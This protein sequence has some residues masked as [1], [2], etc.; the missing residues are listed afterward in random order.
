MP[1][2]ARIDAPGALHHVIV[3]GVE[4]RRIFEDD[5]D[6]HEFLNQLGKVLSDTRT[7]CFAWTLIPNHF[8]L[9]VM[10]FNISR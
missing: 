8:G 1:R 5:I 7:D 6:R 9:V 3:R 4:G 2:Q 10:R